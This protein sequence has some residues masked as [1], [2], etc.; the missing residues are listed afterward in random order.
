MLDPAMERYRLNERRE[1]QLAQQATETT[2]VTT[3][4]LS[5]DLYAE[6]RRHIETGK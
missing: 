3:H 5:A 4:R 1:R 6:L 2:A